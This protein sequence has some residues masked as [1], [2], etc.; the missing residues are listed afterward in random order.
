MGHMD[1]LPHGV[2][3]MGTTQKEYFHL[4]LLIDGLLATKFGIDTGAGVIDT[5]YRG[6]LYILLFNH[7]EK[8]FQGLFL[9]LFLWHLHLTLFFQ[10]VRVIEL[11]S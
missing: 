4:P 9:G 3:L 11:L 2:A 8:D 10:S 5:D 7:G 1:A 6:I